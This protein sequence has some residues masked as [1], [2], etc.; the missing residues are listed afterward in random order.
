M[1]TTSLHPD[2]LQ[3]A[4]ADRAKHAKAKGGKLPPELMEQV[5]EHFTQAEDTGLMNVEQ[6]KEHRLK[7][8]EARTVFV[9]ESEQRLKTYTYNFCEH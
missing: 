8:M 2:A 1:Q 7:L 3:T 6:A 9:Q 5:W 4:K